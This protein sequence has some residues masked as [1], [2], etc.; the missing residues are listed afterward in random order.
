MHEK[1]TIQEIGDVFK[2]REAQ[3]NHALPES[4]YLG[5]RLDGRAFH[6]FTKQFDRPYSWEFMFSMNRAARTVI[7][8]VLVNALFGYV[9]SDEISVICD[10]ER[11]PFGGS[12]EKV[13]SLSASAATAGFMQYHSDIKNSLVGLPL[14]DSRVFNI[15]FD[16]IESY[17]NWRRMDAFRN[18]IS[19]AA[20]M[21]YSDKQL[22]GVSFKQRID[23]LEGTKY[24][25]LPNSYVWGRF[26]YDDEFSEATFI[27]MKEL[28]NKVST[29][30][31]LRNSQ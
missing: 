15:E 6:T 27:E 21:L 4:K 8:E 23:L 13:L 11:L 28:L 20:R 30:V 18:S 24:E 5:I 19:S 16:E 22:H 10:M 29:D 26:F 14:F 17:L 31:D 1:M 2:T 25:D 12:T 3:T 7:K 9:Q